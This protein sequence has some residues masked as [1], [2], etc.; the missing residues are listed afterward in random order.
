MRQSKRR[1]C[2]GA[3]AVFM[4]D[5]AKAFSSWLRADEGIRRS[6]LRRLSV[7]ESGGDS[8]GQDGQPASRFGL[9]VFSGSEVGRDGVDLAESFLKL[10]AILGQTGHSDAGHL[11]APALKGDFPDTLAHESGLIQGALAGD[12]EVGGPQMLSQ[13]GVPGEHI[14]SGLELRAEE[15]AQTIP[16]SASRAG[17]RLGS[18]VRPFR[19]P[20]NKCQ[21]P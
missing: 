4:A 21:A 3:F 5:V 13:L 16:K 8:A 1:A 18:P 10:R 9:G 12:Y 14:K 11:P 19:S 15:D 2:P 17:T 20:S 6:Y 7:G